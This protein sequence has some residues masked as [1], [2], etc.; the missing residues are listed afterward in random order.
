MIPPKFHLIPPKF[1][2]SPTWGFFFSHVEICKSSRE[3]RSFLPQKRLET[4]VRLF[5]L[6]LVWLK[7]SIR[8]GGGIT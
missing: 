7:H 3:K 6:H 8:S 1:Y 4:W 2:F 5:T